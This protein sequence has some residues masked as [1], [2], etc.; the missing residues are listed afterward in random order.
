MRTWSPPSFH[1]CDYKRRVIEGL[2]SR[3][4]Y[5]YKVRYFSLI[6][7]IIIITQF[8]FHPQHQPVSV[9]LMS[10]A[11][12]NPNKAPTT[13][14]STFPFGYVLQPSSVILNFPNLDLSGRIRTDGNVF[15]SKWGRDDF[16]G[17]IRVII[18]IIRV[19]VLLEELSPKFVS[20]SINGKNSEPTR[21]LPGIGGHPRRGN[22]EVFAVE[23]GG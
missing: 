4:L 21:V 11:L 12:V 3:L 14:T 13:L 10:Y 19:K 17:S 9:P 5:C 22:P 16:C 2:L 7:Y 6:F 18:P 1:R 20:S 15:I 23:A 8:I